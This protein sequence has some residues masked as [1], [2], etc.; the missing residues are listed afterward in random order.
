M[1]ECIIA[2]GNID[3]SNGGGMGQGIRT[4]VITVNQTWR[5]PKVRDNTFYIK[6]FGGGGAGGYLTDSRD[7]GV[8]NNSI[9]AAGGGGG[10]GHLNETVISIPSD[11]GIDITV[12]TG[13][14]IN[15]IPGG[16]TGTQWFNGS[17]GGSTSF[18]AYLTAAGGGGG[19]SSSGGGD[20]GSGGSGGGA[21]IAHYTRAP[22][23]GQTDYITRLIGNSS[24]G[25]TGYG[26]GGGGARGGLN[27]NAGIYGGGGGAAPSTSIMWNGGS[28]GQYGGNG[29]AG[30]LLGTGD[31]KRSRNGNNGTSTYGNYN[32]GN[33]GATRYFFGDGIGGTGGN[34]QYNGEIYDLWL[35]GA[36]G[37]GGYGGRGGNG[38]NG[39]FDSI[40]A[41]NST[42]APNIAMKI[43][44]HSILGGSGGGGGYG[45]NGGSGGVP[46]LISIGRVIAV[47]GSGGGGGYGG[48]GRPGTLGG[49]GGGG[50][51]PYGYGHGGDGYKGGEN[52]A[53][54]CV[55]I[56][57]YDPL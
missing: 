56:Q 14:L 3:T 37:G 36:G 12:G 21:G 18:G 22:V 10:G 38:A 41:Q 19:W 50:Y 24:Y 49:G 51:G 40:N 54:G 30:I 46:V 6:V 9:D 31:T 42:I 8:Y 4:E 28:G 48:D 52:G 13:G 33:E 1:G 15:P 20:G 25:S 2:R 27:G 53:S 45:A 5:T 29:G 35:K 55:I 47:G 32:I 11:T 23:V 16:N 7:M 39:I 26:G 57:W 44:Y 34:P 17:S 43:Y